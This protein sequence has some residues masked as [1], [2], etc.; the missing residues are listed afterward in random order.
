MA[1]AFTAP[2]EF[3]PLGFLTSS[4]SLQRRFARGFGSG[5][6]QHTRHQP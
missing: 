1:R 6:F 4:S 5:P 2:P 3:A